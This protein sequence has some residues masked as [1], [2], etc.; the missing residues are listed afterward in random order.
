[1][2]HHTADIEFKTPAGCNVATAADALLLLQ[3]A[4]LSL[5]QLVAV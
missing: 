4:I 5:P 3:T 2:L 1:L